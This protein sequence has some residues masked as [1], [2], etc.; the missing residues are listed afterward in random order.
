MMLPSKD[1]VLKRFL[2]Y[3]RILCR[4]QVSDVLIHR[5][6]FCHLSVWIG[7]VSSD[8]LVCTRL[9]S[10]VCAETTHAAVIEAVMRFAGTCMPA[11]TIFE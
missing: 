8:A 4:F 7:I 9:F 11:I 6:P 10:L 1:I 5:D 2:Y 3:F